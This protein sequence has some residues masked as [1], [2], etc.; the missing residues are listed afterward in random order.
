MSL[1]DE[2][3]NRALVNP[4]ALQK[5]V[6]LL[7]PQFIIILINDA[8]GSGPP[9]LSSQRP[10][11][12]PGELPTLGCFRSTYLPFAKC[13]DESTFSHACIQSTHAASQI[14]RS[15]GTTLY[16]KKID[17]HHDEY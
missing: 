13:R 3:S 7:S 5:R 16:L 2:A 4:L 15:N 17:E 8:P 9:R 11:P 12:F 6:R 14:P 1:R 10:T